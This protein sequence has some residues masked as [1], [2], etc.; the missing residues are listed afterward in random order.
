MSDDPEDVEVPNDLEITIW[1]ESTGYR[2]CADCGTDCEPEPFPTD[3]GIRIAFACPTHGVHSVV[4]P[5]E[6][7]R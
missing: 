3:L 4:D 6:G 1:D 7:R 2:T 5:F